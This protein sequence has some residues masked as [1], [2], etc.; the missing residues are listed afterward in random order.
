MRRIHTFV[1]AVVLAVAAVAG[2]FAVSRTTQLGAATRNHVPARQL[3]ARNRQLDK[4]EQALLAQAQRS[5]HAA[6]QAAAYAPTIYMRPKPIVRVVHRAG[7]EHENEAEGE[8]R[9]DD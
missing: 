5:P 4:I 1:L 6:T 8:G 2:L 7:G 9:F 3:A